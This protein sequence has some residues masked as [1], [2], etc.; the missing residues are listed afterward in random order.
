MWHLGGRSKLKVRCHRHLQCGQELV[1]GR[2]ESGRHRNSCTKTSERRWRLA[3]G[4]TGRRR[5]ACGHGVSARRKAPIST[6]HCAAHPRAAILYGSTRSGGWTCRLAQR[7]TPPRVGAQVGNPP[8]WI[9]FPTGA[10]GS[11]SGCRRRPASAGR[12]SFLAT[13]QSC[14]ADPAALEPVPAQDP[15]ASARRRA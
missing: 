9:A 1:A 14:A 13:P 5:A 11:L 12:F 15:L 7:H 4:S 6:R 3:D 8:T 2:A 10:P